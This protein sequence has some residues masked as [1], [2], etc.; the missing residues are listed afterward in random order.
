MYVYGLELTEIGKNREYYRGVVYDVPRS[1]LVTCGSI[2][3]E[4]VI[5]V[6]FSTGENNFTGLFRIGIR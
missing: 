3:S 6:I 5:F 2:G 1:L 4:N